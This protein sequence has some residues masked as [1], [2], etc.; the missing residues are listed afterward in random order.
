MARNIIT[1]KRI[2][3]GAL[4]GAMLYATT[5]GGFSKTA[6]SDVPAKHWANAS[7]SAIAEGGLMEGYGYNKFGPGDKLNID[8]MAQIICNAKGYVA[9]EAGS[10]WGAN[11]VDYCRDKL[12][13]LPN[14][15]TTSKANYSV[16]C[17]RE[18]AVYMMVK[19]LGSAD[20]SKAN[21]YIKSM[22]IPDWGYISPQYMDAVLKAYKL[23]IVSGTDAKGTFNPKGE[24]SRAEMAQILYNAGYTKSAAVPE[25]TTTLT[26]AQI[27]DKIKAMGIWQ[28]KTISGLRVLRT[29]DP[30]YGG[31]SVTENS[32]GGLSLIAFEWNQDAWVKDG[33]AVDMYGNY[34]SQETLSRG[35]IDENGKF[36][37]S[38]GYSYEA[39]QVMQE[40]LRIAYPDSSEDAISALK[41][42]FYQKIHEMPQGYASAIRWVDGRPL[43]IALSPAPDW[44]ISIFVG[45]DNDRN[46]YNSFLSGASTGTHRIYVPR[47][48]T[49][50]D[51]IAAFELNKW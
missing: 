46:A 34:V 31:L 49:K 32:S 2:V 43:K 39:R 28:E 13:C 30:K 44:A 47:C 1:R 26:N 8:Q 41:D 11:A 20:Q 24:L 48:G 25:G 6:F 15:G 17:T 14:F 35:H 36:V 33:K 5:F 51:M 37:M 22:D 42:V 29:T 16:P 50:E 23:G 21:G 40:V 10:Y 9:D 45:K 27:Y 19:G 3:A 12:H 7:I 38:T 4:V 18:L